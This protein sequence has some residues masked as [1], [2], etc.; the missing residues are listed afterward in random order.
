MLVFAFTLLLTI[1]ISVLL[2]LSCTSRP[3]QNTWNYKSVKF[4]NKPFKPKHT[5]HVTRQRRVVQRPRVLDSS[6]SSGNEPSASMR[7]N[8][9]PGSHAQYSR[10]TSESP[11]PSPSYHPWRESDMNESHHSRSDNETPPPPYELLRRVSTSSRSSAQ[12]VRSDLGAESEERQML[13]REES[14]SD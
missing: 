11:S 14:A 9:D 6:T 13:F 8:R 2:T 1:V 4:I 7:P 12:T 3:H 5:S 10:P